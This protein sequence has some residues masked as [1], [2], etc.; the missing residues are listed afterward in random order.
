MPGKPPDDE[1]ERCRR[2]IGFD[3][4]APV[5]QGDHA[6][7]VPRIGQDVANPAHVDPEKDP[8]EDL[9]AVDEKKNEY[10][11]HVRRVRLRTRIARSGAARIIHSGTRIANRQLRR[12]TSGTP[13]AALFLEERLEGL[14][15]V[16]H[17]FDLRAATL[18]A[19]RCGRSAGRR[20][21]RR[22]GR[23]SGS[24]APGSEARGTPSASSSRRT[25]SCDRCADR[26]HRRTSLPDRADRRDAEPRCTRALEDGWPGRSRGYV[27][28]VL[29]RSAG[30]AARVWLLWGGRDC[31]DDPPVAPAVLISTMAILG[32]A[33]TS[34]SKT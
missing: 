34:T 8:A 27:R 22:R 26:R 15:R 23:P 1:L 25:C 13:G 31:D 30:A 5:E 6:R 24:R 11:S 16:A 3:R 10:C 29:P 17:R 20:T 12:A 9:Q 14:P 18:S 7:L 28:A 21:R 32:I 4:S 2:E 33:H 19:E